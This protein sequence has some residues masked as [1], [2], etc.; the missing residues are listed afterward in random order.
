MKEVLA[1]AGMGRVADTGARPSHDPQD[2]TCVISQQP[3]VC[4][5]LPTAFLFLFRLR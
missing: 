2:H 3:S 4:S 1:N 5:L